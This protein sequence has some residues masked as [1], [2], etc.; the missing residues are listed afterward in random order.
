MDIIN[1]IRGFIFLV[2]G[3]FLIV[4]PKKVYKFQTALIKFLHIKYNLKRDLKYYPHMGIGFIIIS[5]L[6]FVYAITH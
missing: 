2:P 6:L 3:L 1:A 4:S 5:M